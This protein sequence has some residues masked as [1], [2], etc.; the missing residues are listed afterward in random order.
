MEGKKLSIADVK[1]N[2]YIRVIE[3]CVSHGKACLMPD[4]GEELDPTLDTVLNKSVMKIMNRKIMRIGDREIEYNDNFKLYISTR[5]SNPHYTPETSTKV[6]LI[7]FTVKADGLEEQL[8]GIV[9]EEEQ[10]MWEKSKNDQVVKIARN[11]K[12]LIELEDQILKMLQE[13]KVSL[14]EDVELIKALQSSKETSDEV[15]QALE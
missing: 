7:N 14:L 11:K 13:S 6:T 8:L 12:M 15:Q 2:N 3:N 10:P 9:V 4:V 5:M 1:D